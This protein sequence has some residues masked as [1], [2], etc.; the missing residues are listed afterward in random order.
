MRSAARTTST[1]TRGTGPGPGTPRSGGGS[2]KPTAAGSA[3][4]SWSAGQAGITA[5]GA[6]RRQYA[7][8]V[9][10]VPTVLDLLGITPPT[11]IRGVTQAPFHGVSFA[12][13]LDDDTAESRRRTQYF[14][15][16]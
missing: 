16:V 6:V 15:T 2:G 14:E 8:I 3:T 10:M 4:R 13:T 1:T 11:A 5:E 7:H 9:D 12:H